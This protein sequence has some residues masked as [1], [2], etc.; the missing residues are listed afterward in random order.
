M[1]WFYRGIEAPMGLVL[2]GALLALC[3]SSYPIIFFGKSYVSPG[4][5][6][7]MIY[8]QL[9]YV[10]GYL[11]TDKE[12]LSADAGAM[13]WQN[14]PY[15][16]VQHEAVFE[17]GE[18]PLWN[19]YNSAGLPLFG[20]GQSQFLDPLHWIA[21]AGEG[22]SW[23]WDLK[24]LLSKLVF[25]VGIGACVLLMTGNKVATI[26]VTI[27]AAF[28]G[29]F[30]FRFNHP[31]FFNLT[32]APWVFYFYLQL[33]RTIELGQRRWSHKWPALPLVGIFVAS[34]L[35]LFAGTPKEGIILFGGLHFAGLTGVIVVSR[36]LKALLSNIGVL[37]MLWISIALATA[38]HWLIFLDTLSKVST[39]YNTPN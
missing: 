24:F 12:N 19:R 16:R 38:P 9:P 23:A 6:P 15:S 39:I 25:L 35:H 37:I 8:D 14:L 3:L 17:H 36:G 34:V 10:P 27:S 2:V 33:V 22:N 32:Y 7:Q 21:V 11:S 5:G 30:Y 4:Y 29:F 28:I 31:V 18:F 20:Q 1:K 13:P 26:A